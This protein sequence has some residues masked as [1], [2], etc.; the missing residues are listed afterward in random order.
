MNKP[1]KN[2][3]CIIL[4]LALTAG[5]VCGFASAADS[6]VIEPEA[7]DNLF[8]RAV[9]Y[10]IYGI[11]NITDF[12]NGLTV[13]LTGKSVAVYNEITV[14]AGADEPFTFI[15]IS[16]TH[17]ARAN[18][19]DGRAKLE[20]ALKRSRSFRHSVMMLD[21]TAKKA[22]ELG[23][24]VVHTGDMIDF[25]SYENLKIAKD[26]TGKVDC[27]MLAG[28]HEFSPTVYND[29]VSHA[30]LTEYFLDRVQASYKNDIR[31]YSRVVNGVNLV[32]LDNGSHKVE[33]WQVEKLREEIDRGLPVLLFLHVP[34]YTPE[35]Y[36]FAVSK[37]GLPAWL[38]AVPED[39]LAGYTEADRL[40]QGA[41]EP[42]KE[43]YDLIVNSSN[44]KAI[45]C[46]HEHYDHI[47]MVTPETPQYVINC[48]T[49]GIVTVK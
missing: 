37:Y 3:V 25:V 30:E 19:S 21:E 7:E 6:S 47:S 46:G 18:M 23:C 40:S 29:P 34:V 15:H 48:T 17:L 26:F 31:F 45:F 22:D 1:V 27:I 36:E 49:A 32:A 4:S 42:T 28:N 44:I 43:A 14:D 41:D 24:F 35:E 11:L 8:D 10:A 33:Q 38:M 13:K 12:F 2:I 39:K 20:L 5:S 9:S 16:D